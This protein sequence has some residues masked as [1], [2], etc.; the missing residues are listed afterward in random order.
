MGKIH[1][2]SSCDVCVPMARPSVLDRFLLL[3]LAA[4]KIS[5]AL[6]NI[7]FSASVAKRPR[8][9]SAYCSI[10]MMVSGVSATVDGMVI[11]W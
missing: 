11:P 3:V 4:P 6:K 5:T 8:V 2:F 7:C 1:S 9:S 10:L